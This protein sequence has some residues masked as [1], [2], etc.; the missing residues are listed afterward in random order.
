[1]IKHKGLKKREKRKKMIALQRS[2]ASRVRN[3]TRSHDAYDRI[4]INIDLINI[5]LYYYKN[6]LKHDETLENDFC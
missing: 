4:F 3:F 5:K 6:T 2:P 1:M